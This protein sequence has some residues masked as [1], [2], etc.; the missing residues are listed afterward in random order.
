MTFHAACTFCCRPG[1][2]NCPPSRSHVGLPCGVTVTISRRRAC[3][4]RARRCR[5]TPCR[6][7]PSHQPHACCACHCAHLCACHRHPAST[8][9]PPLYPAH[10]GHRPPPLLPSPRLPSC[11]CTCR[12]GS[13]ARV[14]GGG[15]CG[16]PAR[17]PLHRVPGALGRLP[18]G[19][20]G[21][22]VHLAA[23]RTAA[24]GPRQAHI[25]A[26]AAGVA[27]AGGSTPAAGAAAS[28][29]GAAATPVPA[30]GSA[31]TQQAAAAGS[32]SRQQQRAAAADVDTS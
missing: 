31:A 11:P 27:A 12:A 5:T 4:C 8:G 2:P 22:G 9:R 20:R 32:G 13:G 24:A 30:G 7:C 25:S 18:A 10:T 28:L 6:L 14:R 15:L 21:G 1:M 26:A 29:G 16:A 17:G 3:S 23:G 19:G